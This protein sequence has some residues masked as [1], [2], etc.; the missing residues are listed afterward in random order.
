MKITATT[1]MMLLAGVV[2][3]G[4]DQRAERRVTVC[5]EGSPASVSTQGSARSLASKIFADIGMQID[6]RP[7]LDGCPSDGIRISLTDN[8]PA[9]YASSRA[10]S[11]RARPDPNPE[12]RPDSPRRRRA[13]LARHAPPRPIQQN[14]PHDLG[15]YGEEMDAV[16]PVHI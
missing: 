8:T 6:W 12:V 3:Q 1:T 4:A 14:V 5:I 2:A 16:L 7:G 9:S 15:R 13:A 10:I 11:S